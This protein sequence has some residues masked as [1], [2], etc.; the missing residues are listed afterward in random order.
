MSDYLKI[1]IGRGENIHASLAFDEDIYCLG[2]SILYM[3]TGYPQLQIK[4][5]MHS[6]LGEVGKRYSEKLINLVRSMIE[7]NP[8]R[9]MSI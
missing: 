4:Q 9:R 5:N 6:V 8:R 3:M 2:Y 1:R 7:E